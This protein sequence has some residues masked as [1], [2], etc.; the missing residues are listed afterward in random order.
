MA[1]NY[2]SV[3]YNTLKSF[4]FIDSCVSPINLE[5]EYFFFKLP[6]ILEVPLPVVLDCLLFSL[7]H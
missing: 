2:K 5:L 6:E 3:F 1:M 4:F 7:A